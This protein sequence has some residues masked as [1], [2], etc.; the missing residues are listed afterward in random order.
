MIGPAVLLWVLALTQLSSGQ[1][2]PNSKSEETALPNVR[3][4]EKPTSDNKNTQPKN[5]KR[6]PLAF[7]L[8]EEQPTERLPEH[9][10]K[11]EVLKINSSVK[12]ELQ[13]PNEER[14]LK[15]P[16]SKWV[17][18]AVIP[19]AKGKAYL[20]CYAD[21]PRNSILARDLNDLVANPSTYIREKDGWI[22]VLLTLNHYPNTEKA[23]VELQ[24]DSTLEGQ[25]AA[26]FA[27]PGF[28]VQS[29][30][31]SGELDPT[32]RFQF[33]AYLD[34]DFPKGRL[35]DLKTGRVLKDNLG[36][37][38][39]KSVTTCLFSKDGSH[40]AVISRFH[41]KYNTHLEEY[42]VYSLDPF[43]QVANGSAKELRDVRFAD[44]NKTLEF[45][46]S[47]RAKVSGK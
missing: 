42:W 5:T 14:Q 4:E 19:P 26:Y 32:G 11:K 9:S 47:G 23:C 2:Q 3:S 43:K 33:Q 35:V 41:D 17:K 36:I 6:I 13:I 21:N 34:R 8:A 24:W 12:L 18:F 1:E 10:G 46:S 25:T 22:E 37:G 16:N 15:S 27:D 40:A 31:S 30:Q 38:W 28:V 7:K 45:K 20:F 39:M 44:D 29:N